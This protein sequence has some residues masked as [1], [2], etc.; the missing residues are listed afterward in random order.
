MADLQ[1]AYHHAVATAL[2][3]YPYA[4]PRRDDELYLPGR[5]GATASYENGIVKYVIPEVPWL[6][7][8]DDRLHTK[9]KRFWIELIGY[10]H[11]KANIKV[12]FE[13]ALCLIK[14]YH[15]LNAPWDLDNRVYN[16]IINAIRYTKLIPDDSSKHLSVMVT[17]EAGSDSKRTE[18]YVVD[19]KVIV[20]KFQ[21][22]G[23]AI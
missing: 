17:G 2:E 9:L 19:M 5:A 12:Q 22:L 7:K 1:K 18:I 16:H 3:L 11:S 4:Y 14:V 8:N 21:E 13:H 23:I 20:P 10:A 15:T 6:I